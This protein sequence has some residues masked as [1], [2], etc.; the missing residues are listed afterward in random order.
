MQALRRQIAT[1]GLRIRLK[2]ERRGHKNHEMSKLVKVRPNISN[3]I[4]ARKMCVDT[5]AILPY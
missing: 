5:N 3:C 4:K 2:D 1:Q